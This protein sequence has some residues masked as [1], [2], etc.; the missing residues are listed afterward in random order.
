MSQ[1]LL[2]QVDSRGIVFIKNIHYDILLELGEDELFIS[3]A[4]FF[5]C[6]HWKKLQ[7][8]LYF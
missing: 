4:I 6:L 3:T 7:A 5:T 1:G 2:F 8:F